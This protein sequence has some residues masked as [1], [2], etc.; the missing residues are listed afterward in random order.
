MTEEEKKEQ[1]KKQNWKIPLL[2]LAIL[3]YIGLAVSSFFIFGIKTLWFVIPI[4]IIIIGAVLA[5]IILRKDEEEEKIIKAPEKEYVSTSN[6]IEWLID[7][8]YFLT[9]DK[10]IQKARL[11]KDGIVSFEK[12]GKTYTVFVA[13]FINKAK[14]VDYYI[15]TD[16]IQKIE[17]KKLEELMKMKNEVYFNYLRNNFRVGC[18]TYPSSEKM[19]DKILDD[20]KKSIENFATEKDLFREKR[21][22]NLDPETGRQTIYD[23]REP[24]Y[25]PEKEEEKEVEGAF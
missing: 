15:F 1:E 6:L 8:I 19:T 10:I 13:N 7:Y 14:R 17:F 12:A 2:I 25:E 16:A 11:G 5:V 4:S 18:A 24:A 23:S 9:G 22:I 21:I 3:V 20:I